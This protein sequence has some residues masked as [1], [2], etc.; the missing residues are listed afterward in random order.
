MI[1]RYRY[2]LLLSV[3]TF[4]VAGCGQT[5]SP[6]IMLPKA[7]L[8]EREVQVA[9][10][11]GGFPTVGENFPSVTLGEVGMIRY[12]VTDHFTLQ[13][14]EWTGGFHPIGTSLEGIALLSDRTSSWRFALVPR[15]AMMNSGYEITG[16][17]S[18]LSLAAW[19]PDLLGLHPYL[20]AGV[21]VGNGHLDY[22]TTTVADG[23]QLTPDQ[24]YL[25]GFGGA[26][27]AGLE[28]DIIE[29]ISLN[30]EF[31]T[32]GIIIRD[33]PGNY[34]WNGFWVWGLAAGYHF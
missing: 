12:G 16:W 15:I 13:G 17:G 22:Q 33:S 28:Y 2:L 19:T 32:S 14:E 24:R 25:I 29:H 4:L 6:F 34:Y 8:Q 7:P 9:G 26:L 30:A 10:S 11:V 23:L 21:L 31:A 3:F 1:S 18:S 27:N 20:G 5:Y